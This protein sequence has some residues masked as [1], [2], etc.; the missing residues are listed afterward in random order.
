MNEGRIVLQQ[1]RLRVGPFQ[2]VQRPDQTW[3]LPGGGSASYRDCVALTRR[4]AWPQPK[5]VQVRVRYRAEVEGDFCAPNTT[6]LM[7]DERRP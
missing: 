2:L 5:L 6:T 4:L 1:H 3:A 7:A